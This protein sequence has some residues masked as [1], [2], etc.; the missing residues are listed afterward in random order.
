GNTDSVVIF[1]LLLSVWLTDNNA[2]DWASGAALGAA[3]CVKVVPLIVVPVLFFYRSGLRRRVIFLAAAAAVILVCWSPYV[4]QNPVAVFHQVLGYRSGYGRWGLS[5][6]FLHLRHFPHRG[7]VAFERLG[8]AAL[9]AFI[10][11]AAFFINRSETRPPLYRQVGAA[12]LVFL[13]ATSSFAVQHLAWLV[14][15]S[16]G[17]DLYSVGFFQ[18]AGGIFLFLVYN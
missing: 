8:G 15:W 12:F 10:T 7:N 18:L 6:L 16:V 2:P 17:V 3:M 9:L 5:W 1:F 14:P 11:L 13:A 4:Y